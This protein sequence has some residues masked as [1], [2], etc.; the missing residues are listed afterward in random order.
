MRAA[1][2]LNKDEEGAFFWGYVITAVTALGYDGMS[3]E[4]DDIEEFEHP[5]GAVGRARYKKILRLEWR[6]PSFE[7]L[8]AK[9]D[10]APGTTPGLFDRRATSNRMRRVRVNET[11]SRDVPKRMAKAL[12][13]PDYLEGIG[14][15]AEH[16]LEM[17]DRPFQVYNVEM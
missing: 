17:T 15:L 6:H 9:V 12:F 4:E 7:A 1:S 10:E 8:F 2:E 16:T 11:S 5:N 13:N 14:R 3:D